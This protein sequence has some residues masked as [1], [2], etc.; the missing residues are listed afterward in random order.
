MDSHQNH[1]KSEKHIVIFVLFF[2][3][4]GGILGGSENVSTIKL[5]KKVFRFYFFGSNNLITNKFSWKKGTVKKKK[6]ANLPPFF[7]FMMLSFTCISASA[8]P[9]NNKKGRGKDA[10]DD[11]KTKASDHFS[12]AW[13]F[14]SVWKNKITL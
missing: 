2:E 13:D 4:G 8:Q 6:R 3:R 12:L 11:R 7:W 14:K 1:Q 5:I 10:R 9:L